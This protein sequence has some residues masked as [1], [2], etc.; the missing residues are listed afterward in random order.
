MTND[1]INTVPLLEQLTIKLLLRKAQQLTYEISLLDT[2]RY[3]I[4][5]FKIHLLFSRPLQYDPEM[6]A[7]KKFVGCRGRTKR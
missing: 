6:I 5:Y 3:Y 4:R 1:L 7:A 2:S